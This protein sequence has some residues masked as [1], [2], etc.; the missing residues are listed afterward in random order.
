VTTTEH[1]LSPARERGTLLIPPSRHGSAAVI[2][3]ALIAA[4]GLGYALQEGLGPVDVMRD[5]RLEPLEGLSI[6]AV[7]GAARRG[8]LASVASRLPPVARSAAG[9]LRAVATGT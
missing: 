9:D 3:A 8:A 2:D 6:V 1:P 4:A 7:R 5:G